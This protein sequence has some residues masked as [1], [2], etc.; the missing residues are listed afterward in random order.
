MAGRTPH[1]AKVLRNMIN[2]K[3]NRDPA[4]KAATE[5]MT[6]AG[7]PDGL[8]TY[9]TF[10]FDPVASKVL[11]AM[12]DGGW[13]DPRISGVETGGTAKAPKVTLTFVSGISADDRSPFPV[14]GVDAPEEELVDQT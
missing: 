14:D 8:G 5:M 6:P 10:E 1:A 3:L 9:R 12:L 2:A 11:K 13:E 4:G 7:D